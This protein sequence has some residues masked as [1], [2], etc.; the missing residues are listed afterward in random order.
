MEGKGGGRRKVE[1][2]AGKEGKR[3]TRKAGGKEQ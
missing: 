3:E 2:R 1:G